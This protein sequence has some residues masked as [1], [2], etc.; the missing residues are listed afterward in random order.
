M[1]TIVNIVSEQ[2]LPNYL[3][4]KEVYEQEDNVIWIVSKA[5]RI[6]T[7]IKCLKNT[8]GE[9]TDKM[10]YIEDGSEENIQYIKEVLQTNIDSQQNFVVNL[11]G[12]T[13]IM[14]LAVY[15]F[16][17]NNVTNA[18]FYYIPF[19]KNIIIDISSQ[20]IKQI[21]HKIS[22]EK[23]L[24]LYNLKVQSQGKQD[25]VLSFKDA[26]YMYSNMYNLQK[27]YIQE[28]IELRELKEKN[29]FKGRNNRDKTYP[30]DEISKVKLKEDDGNKNTNRAK[31]I[32][33]FILN[34]NIP[35]LSEK[36]KIG[37]KDIVYITGG[38]FE[39]FIFYLTKE[40]EK[41]DDI[42]LGIEILKQD[43]EQSKN[44]LDVVY[45]KDNKFFIRECKTAFE[46]ERMFNEII[47]TATAIKS[48][49]GLS[50]KS[51]VYCYREK[52][53]DKDD[54][55]ARM[56]ETLNKMGITYFGKKDIDD[57]LN[58]LNQSSL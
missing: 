13:K 50:T 36:N 30:Y 31:R 49:F 38:W 10:I 29:K 46:K 39:D 51:S 20:N 23:Y 18:E 37:Y 21:T 2:T 7:A 52:L 22:V 11:T 15:D 32:E 16:F 25:G 4:V 1:K 26:K 9:I 34:N 5:D 33:D 47:Y 55:Q 40:I 54:E 12:G 17:R 44:E 48:L 8:I 56:N 14:A 53:S 43:A 24:K 57:E 58:K 19:P 35:T 42:V 41:P 28:L 45:T 3:F 27:E 6:Q